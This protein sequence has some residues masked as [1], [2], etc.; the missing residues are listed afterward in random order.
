MEKILNVCDI[1][2]HPATQDNGLVW[3]ICGHVFCENHCQK[4]KEKC[5]VC[6][7]TKGLGA[8]GNVD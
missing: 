8:T 4:S 5:S 3:E 7:K 6:E 2:E 1:C